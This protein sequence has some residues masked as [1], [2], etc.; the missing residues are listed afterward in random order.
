MPAKGLGRAT[1]AGLDLV[2]ADDLVPDPIVDQSALVA[3]Q[4]WLWWGGVAPPAAVQIPLS[5]LRGPARFRH[6]PPRQVAEVTQA[7]GTTATSRAASLLPTDRQWVFTATLD[8]LVSGDTAN[9][10]RWVTTYYTSPLPRANAYSLVLNG[11][12]VPEIWRILGV[13]VGTRISITGAPGTPTV[14][15]TN[16]SFDA[17]IGSWGGVNGATI[18]SSA[19]QVHQ[20][21]LAM[22]V[23][24]D[25]V[26]GF[27]GAYASEAPVAPGY[28]CSYS[29]WIWS[30][31][32]FG[33]TAGV[34][35]ND[36]GHNGISDNT[37]GATV[38]PNWTRITGTTPAAPAATA[39]ASLHIG[40]N[41]TPSAAVVA[42]VDDASFTGV[43]PRIGNPW[44]RGATELIVE[45]I[46]HQILGDARV[47]T[48]STSPIIGAAPGVAGPWFR[49]DSSRLGST[50]AMPF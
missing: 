9:L 20:G 33:Y 41:G 24:P 35:F 16:T 15:N 10:A 13:K 32:S 40:F 45:G 22:Q 11:R 37:T 49:L 6:D 48:W 25:G 44:P 17:G 50:N 3:A 14:L 39:S 30:T 38:G 31:S 18:A 2:D 26:S 46:T 34:Q 12:T 36:A 29:V 21:A 42:Y 8:T 7:G 27:P 4:N 1:F 5:W 19:A 43:D 23:T 47:V 28:S